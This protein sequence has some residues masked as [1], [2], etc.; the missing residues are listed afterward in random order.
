MTRLLPAREQ[1]PGTTRTLLVERNGGD[2]VSRVRRTVLPGGLRV[3]TEAMPGVRSATLGVWVGVGSRDEAPSLSGASH[4]LEH[5]LF[6]GTRRRS[7]LE[8]SAAL[9]AVGG[10]LNAFTTKEYTCY[11]ARVID[12]D[13]PTAI[14]VV[15]DMVSSSVVSRADV[16]AER[17]VILDE[18]AMHDDDPDDVVHNLFQQRLWDGTPLGRPVIGAADSIRTLTREQVVGYYRR[19]YRAD[20]TVVAVAGNVDHAT[21]VRQVRAAFGRS[22]FLRDA[23]TAPRDPRGGTT[24]PRSRS[25]SVVR[26]R[27]TEQA[28]FVLGVPA[29]RRSDDRRYALGVL[30]VVLGG[31]PSSRLFQEVRE[32]RG[33]AYSV[34]SYHGHYADT[35]MFGVAAGCLPAKIDEVLEICRGEL[36]RVA[37]H[38]VT[39]DEL[40]LGKG[41]LKG[42]SVLGLEDSGSRMARIAKAELLHGELVGLGELLRRV[43][44]VTLDDVRTLAV[45]LLEAEPTLAVVG[46]FDESRR[47][48]SAVA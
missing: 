33:L 12:Q 22:D 30:N 18:I 42:A 46:P 3:V 40:E 34:Y 1:K 47:F 32:R 16:E 9:D 13:L 25:G 2:V 11:H 45:A 19:R 31:G 36:L 43:D 39:A 24:V 4:F 48:D 37:E 23:D 14:D 27:T 6:K 35:G 5:V 21:V 29:L 15:A 44:A 41:Q 20:N 28:S 10:E 17:D 8:I 38:G 7:A 26:H